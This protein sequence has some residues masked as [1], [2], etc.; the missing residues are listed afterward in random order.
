[1]Q[2]RAAENCEWCHRPLEPAS[3]T[4]G[5]APPNQTET[6]APARPP[7]AR[8]SGATLVVVLTDIKALFAAL[9]SV[10]VLIAAGA[11]GSPVAGPVVLP[12][13]FMLPLS[14]GVLVVAHFC[15]NGYNWARVAVMVLLILGALGQIG[16]AAGP[17]GFQLVPALQLLVQVLCIAILNTEPVKEY[18][19][20]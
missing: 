16:R 2:T 10:V 8:P 18:C 7:T 4:R 5:A 20:R 13:L 17:T 12:A 14:I 19:S 11:S 6:R 15:W 1:M 3:L 9:A